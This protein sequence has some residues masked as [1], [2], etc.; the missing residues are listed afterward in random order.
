MI[1]INADDVRIIEKTLK[2]PDSFSTENIGKSPDRRTKAIVS[3]D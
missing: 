2:E 1:E 3:L